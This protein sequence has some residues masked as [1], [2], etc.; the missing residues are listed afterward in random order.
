MANFKDTGIYL[1]H[2]G[3]FIELESATLVF[4]WYQGDMP[5]IRGDKPLYIFASNIQP[6]HFRP[7]ILAQ[8]S[9]IHMQRFL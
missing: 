2:S 4:D 8:L 6:D 5:P 7:E 9:S 3:F 1:G